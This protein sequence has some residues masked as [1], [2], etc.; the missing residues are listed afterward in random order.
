MM[1]GVIFDTLGADPILELTHQ[2]G[3]WGLRF[4]LITL[5]IT[6]LRYLTGRTFWVKYRRMLGLYSFFYISIHLS[7]YIL[8]LGLFWQQLIEDIIKRPYVTVGFSA[9]LLMIPLAVTSNRYMIRRLG[10]RWKP[11]HKSIYLITPLGILHFIWLV[12]A[13][14]REPLIYGGILLVL[15]ALRVLKKYNRLPS[16]K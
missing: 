3:L 1:S 11:L 14:L 16:F 8:D 15:L 9:F 10:K 4:L 2:T 13:D 12:K 6:P 5:S 7:I